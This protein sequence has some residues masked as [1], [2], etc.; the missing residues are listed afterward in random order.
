MR[1]WIRRG[2][3]AFACA[4]PLGLLGVIALL[5]LVGE[6]SWVTGTALYLPRIVFG[7]PLVVCVPALLWL[8]KPKLLWTQLLALWLLL[9]PLMGLVLPGLSTQPDPSQPRVRVL[10]Y[11]VNSGRAGAETLAARVLSKAPD[12][13]LF[14]ELLDNEAA[15]EAEL[16]K[17]FPWVRV[18]GQFAIASRLPLLAA[19]V[20]RRLLYRGRSHSA[21]FM[22]YTVST[23]FGPLGIY[24]VH[25]LSPRRSFYALRGIGFRSSWREGSLWRGGHAES[26]IR[27]NYDLRELQLKAAVAALR[28]DPS[29]AVLCGD[30]NLTTLSPLLTH[31]DGLQDG[32]VR[33]S[34]G[35]GYSFPSEQPW[36]R[37]DRI[38]AND[39]LEFERFET[40]C[41]LD[42]DHQCVVADL[43]LRAAKP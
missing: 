22:Q 30:T 27:A 4:Y 23:P 10:S 35:F 17:H 28:A 1:G 9:F 43:T 8:R 12:V 19:E 32:F 14:Q 36:M 2:V 39:Q 13:V 31:F 20:P 7:A 11:N 18:D 40:N 3:L 26:V 16:R 5:R 24:N 41:E 37:L 15:V 34:A 38:Y 42:S 29:P 25:F 33:A 21:H 6:G